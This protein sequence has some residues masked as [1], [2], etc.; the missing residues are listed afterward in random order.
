MKQFVRDILHKEAANNFMVFKTEGRRIAMREQI[1]TDIEQFLKNVASLR[2]HYGLS[3][4][5][6][7]QILGIGIGS[8]NKLEQGIFPGRLTVDVIF[9]MTKYFKITANLFRKLP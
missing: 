1:E 7:A 5:R 2:K 9:N 4:K 3:K 8:Y 6:M